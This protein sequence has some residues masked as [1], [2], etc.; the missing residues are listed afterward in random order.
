MKKG[1]FKLKSGN[2]PMFKMMGSK[3]IQRA[4]KSKARKDLLD[5]LTTEEKAKY[6]ALSAKEKFNVSQNV[7]LAQM[8]Q[9]LSDDDSPIEKY[10]SDAQRKAVHASKAERSPAKKTY[11]QAYADADKKKY[12]TYEK[13]LKAAKAYNVKKYGTTEP[14]RE[15]KKLKPVYSD[16]KGVKSGKKK[17][18]KITKYKTV[19]KAASKVAE[20]KHEEKGK[21][22][23]KAA[24]D[25]SMSKQGPDLSTREGRKTA[26]KA[27]KRGKGAGLSKEAYKAGRKKIRKAARK[28]IF[29]KVGKFLKEKVVKLK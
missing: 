17:L 14:T 8:K 21:T 13:F 2:S 12:P 3:M 16:V 10:V 4:H 15:A 22:M 24:R 26:K 9:A 29:G 11:K 6:D 28:D 18:E 20:K 19:K 25:K 23:T 27:L 5:K 1:P 7:N